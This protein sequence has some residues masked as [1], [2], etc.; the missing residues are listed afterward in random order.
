MYLD[1]HKYNV[2]TLLSG[3]H[4]VC[5]DHQEIKLSQHPVVQTEYLI[6]TRLLDDLVL[7]STILGIF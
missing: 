3:I 2:E 7:F 6:P 4:A 1:H 5:H